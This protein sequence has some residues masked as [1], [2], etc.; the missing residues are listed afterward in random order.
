MQKKL[1]FTLVELLVVIAIIGILVGMLLPAVQAIREAAR[2]ITCANNM[3]QIGIACHH[4]DDTFGQLPY[5]IGAPGQDLTTQQLNPSK[6]LHPTSYPLVILAPFME[7]NN[8]SDLVDPLARNIDA[9]LLATT[10]YGDR[11]GWLNGV[12][13]N[14]RGLAPAMTG[15]FPF[16]ICPSDTGGAEENRAQGFHQVGAQRGMSSN[17]VDYEDISKTNYVISWGGYP[18]PRFPNNSS[19]EGF[20]GPIRVRESD[21]VAGIVDG[22]SNVV[23]YGETLG[24][25]VPEIDFSRRPSMALGG[26]VCARVDGLNFTVGGTGFSKRIEAVFGSID[27]SF[28]LQFG[29]AHPQGVNVVRGDS[30]TIF[31]NRGI[32]PET[33]GFL[34]GSADGN[35]VPTYN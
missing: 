11:T 31:L 28:N 14:N 13:A 35:V 30:S 12:D 18:V 23:I 33:F 1:G 21:G 6:R 4:H 32:D 10:I 16:A 3:R 17:F 15:K 27:F 29:S 34:C 22:S 2:R 24:I 7:Q 8:L 26:G 19:F 9:P 20:Y 25:V 5:I